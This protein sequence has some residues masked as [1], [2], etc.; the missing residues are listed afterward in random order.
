LTTKSIAL[1]VA[2][3]F[4]IA[5]TGLAVAQTAAAPPA[6][7]RNTSKADATA[8]SI[9]GTVK[10][11][12]ADRVVVAGKEHGRDAERTFV[13]DAATT[14][15]KGGKD[16]TAA[17]LKSGDAVQVRYVDADGKAHADAITVQGSAK[18]KPRNPCAAVK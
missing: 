5:P 10:S 1:L 14:L 6:Q 4:V 7:T 18:A 17:D 13:I 16:I 2:V 3:T 9:D 11:V 8:K 15:K 12:S